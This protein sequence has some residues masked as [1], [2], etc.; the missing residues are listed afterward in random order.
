MLVQKGTV[1]GQVTEGLSFPVLFKFVCH[2]FEHDHCFKILL[3]PSFPILRA[4]YI[5]SFDSKS[6]RRILLIVGNLTLPKPP[7]SSIELLMVE[8]SK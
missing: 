5:L 4:S 6:R 7:L 2:Q 3:S 1:R 8:G